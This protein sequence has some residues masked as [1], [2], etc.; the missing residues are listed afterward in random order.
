MVIDLGLETPVIA[1][2]GLFGQEEDELQ[3]EE[4]ASIITL[5]FKPV[6]LDLEMLQASPEG[7]G[8]IIS[9]TSCR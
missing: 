7:W 2:L 5:T 1:R 8:G 6:P 9:W 4:M 3:E